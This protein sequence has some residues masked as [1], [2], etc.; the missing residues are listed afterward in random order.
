LPPEKRPAW[1]LQRPVSAG[2]DPFRYLKERKKSK[3]VSAQNPGRPQTTGDADGE[4]LAGS[5]SRFSFTGKSAAEIQAATER[6]M[7]MFYADTRRLVKLKEESIAKR[8]RWR[9]FELDGDV[10]YFNVDSGERVR[11][12]DAVSRFG[13]DMRP[14]TFQ[15]LLDEKNKI[16]QYNKQ[17]QATVSS[18]R[19]QRL[20]DKRQEERQKKR[21]ERKAKLQAEKDK[22]EFE[23][24]QKAD[25]A[26]ASSETG[27]SWNHIPRWICLATGQYTTTV[28]L[29]LAQ[30]FY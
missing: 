24:A 27:T 29:I 1:P 26:A 14:Q 9:R 3:R 6:E 5:P 12:V 16:H 17:I 22:R 10:S 28:L 18:M 8:F 25:A 15:E 7:E 21:D 11:E 19:L 4:A 2:I 30:A 23:A 20:R 13:D